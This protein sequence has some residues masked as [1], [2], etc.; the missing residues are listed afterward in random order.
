MPVV[1]HPDPFAAV[2]LSSPALLVTDEQRMHVRDIL[3]IACSDSKF[4][5]KAYDA[6]LYVLTSGPAQVPTLASVSPNTGVTLNSV[7][8]TA[9]GTNFTSGAKIVVSGVEQETTFVSPTELT[10]LVALGEP[11]ILP[12]SV[13]SATGILTD[14][15]PFT[16]TS[17]MALAGK[18][19]QQY[20]KSEKVLQK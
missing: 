10:A 2:L 8:L 13:L 9:H 12:V 20:Q 4:A 6:I 5:Q 18:T 15:V 19:D 14:S 7:T 11:G 17:V 16:V 3:E 1:L